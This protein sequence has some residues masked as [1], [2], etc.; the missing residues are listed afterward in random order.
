MP[1][2]GSGIETPEQL[3][4]Y[5]YKSVPISE[6]ASEAFH[7]ITPPPELAD[8]WERF[9]DAQAKNVEVSKDLLSALNDQ[10]G[11]KAVTLLSELRSINAEQVAT[12]RALGVEGCV[13]RA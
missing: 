7:E 11:P 6:E 9:L 2:I 8:E 5:V 12:A 1:V 3:R 13:Q 4:T 10:D